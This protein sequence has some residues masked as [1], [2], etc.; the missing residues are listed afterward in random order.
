MTK[1]K[2][3]K[4][5]K[6]RMRYYL[7]NFIMILVLCILFPMYVYAAELQG[8][9][10][11]ELL[12]QY[13]DYKNRLNRIEMRSEIEINEFWL[14]ETQ[15]FPLETE[16]FGQVFLLPAIEKKYNRLVLFLAKEDGTIVYRTDDFEV[17]N[18]LKGE[19]WQP[20][21]RISAVS[22]Q[23]LNGDNLMDIVL[24]I[25][26]INKEGEYKGKEYKVGEVLFQS[27]DGFYRDYRI[28]DKVNRFGMNR[29]VECIAAF[30]RDGYS[31]EFLY[32]ANTKRE[33]LEN[34][35]VIATDQ[36]Y[37]RQFEKLGKL[38]V[39]PG[40]YTIANFS[41]FMVYLI[42][43]Q[44]YI[45]WSLQPM[46]AYDNLYALKGMKCVDIDG[47]GMKDI[48][49]LA[50]YSSS[51]KENELVIKNDYSIYYQRTGGFV[52][53]TEVKKKVYLSEED[54]MAILVEKARA[55]WGWSDS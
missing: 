47:D 36:C 48:L 10:D 21:R 53:D 32:T 14:V 7:A 42:N 45:V 41:I 30:V 1:E 31:T 6:K 29:S 24:I 34:G 35:F 26:C 9:E 2:L 16:K 20:A 50:R 46:G 44:G 5:L 25:S 51:G 23:E 15:I 22:F 38:E 13:Q 3:V 49:V 4:K 12:K 43:E 27:E 54:T 40:T 8:E 18:W 55:C 11:A 17:N 28:S 39:V 52:A 19:M 37:P 33:L